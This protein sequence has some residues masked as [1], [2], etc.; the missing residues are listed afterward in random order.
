MRARGGPLAVGCLAVL[1]ASFPSRAMASAAPLNVIPFPGTPDASPTTGV[2]FSALRPSELRSVLVTGSRSGEHSGQLEALPAGAGTVFV[3]HPAF[4]PGET[5]RVSAELSSAS[6]GTA[7]GDPG[8]TRL[9]FSFSVGSSAGFPVSAGMGLAQSGG[10]MS[11]SGVGPTQ[12]FHSAPGLRPPR[13]TVTPDPDRSSGDMFVAPVNSPQ[14]GPMILDSQG[15]L[16]WWHPVTDTEAT[17]FA[18]QQ[19]QG[20]PVLTWWQGEVPAPGEDVI[21]SRSYRTVA[22]VHAGDGYQAELHEF[23]ITPR[24]AAFITCFAPAFT[25]LTSVG[26]PSNGGVIDGVIQEVDI[27]TGKVLWEWHALGHVPLD[28]S[29]TPY[30]KNQFYDFFHLNSIQQLRDGNLLISARNT[31]SVYEISR[32]TGKVIWTL[33]GKYSNFKMGPGTNFEWQHDA[34]LQDHTL[35]L[36]DDAATPQEERQSSAKYLKVDPTARTVSLVRRFTHTPP[37]L[38]TASGGVQTLPN[39]NSFVSW[40]AVPEFSEFTPGG[41]QIFNGSFA[42]GVW[43]YRAFRFPWIGQPST[44]P[45]VALSSASHGWL[46]VYAS[47]NGAT[48]VAAWRVL[49]G[50]GPHDLKSLGRTAGWSGFETSIAVPAGPRYLA[51]QALNRTG[52]VLAVSAPVRSS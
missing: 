6:A 26:G 37:V 38:A 44:R 29:H 32:S 41:R 22:V 45:S 5:V 7:S 31:W 43:T 28:A 48:Q 10:W 46:R 16:V 51:V 18:V 50:A 30:V 42:L 19:Y 9:S 36:L 4:T 23:Q 34:R 25:N 14:P 12:H 3:P 35:S 11:A 27:R 49:G 40:G 20:R 8:A 17:N 15:R 47:W 33:G 52:R 2:I 21:M 13:L 24:G 1:L 39:H